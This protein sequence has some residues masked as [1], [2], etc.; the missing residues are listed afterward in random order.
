[1]VIN[2]TSGSNTN[3][4]VLGEVKF[5]SRNDDIKNGVLYR[6]AAGTG[7]YKCPSDNSLSISDKL[8]RNRSYSLDQ[9]LTLYQPFVLPDAL[10][11]SSQVLQPAAVFT[12]I[13]ENANCIEDGNFGLLH[14]PTMT[15]L[16]LPSDRHSKGCVIAFL[17]G[18]VKRYA[19]LWSKFFTSYSQLAVNTKDL[20]DLQ[21]LQM[22]LPNPP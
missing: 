10:R 14:S 3:S 6:Y 16:N 17:D 1:T 2:G 11:K 8:P 19:W 12:F 4:W 15:C 21:T 22:A 13:D 9:L 7:I 20:Q 5:Y 18:H